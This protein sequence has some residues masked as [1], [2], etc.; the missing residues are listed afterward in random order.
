VIV[1]L[2][3][4]GLDEFM[5]KAAR[6]GIMLWTPAEP[7]AQQDVLEKAKKWCLYG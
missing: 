2:Q 5:C 6:E 4:D 7:K 3:P 1:D